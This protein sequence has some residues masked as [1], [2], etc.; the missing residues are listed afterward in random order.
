M[1]GVGRLEEVLGEV[2]YRFCFTFRHTVIISGQAARVKDGK[3]RRREWPVFA[4]FRGK[5]GT[6]R[7][8]E[9]KLWLSGHLFYVKSVANVA[10]T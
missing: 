5:I 3:V 10:A 4:Y 2:R 1:D 6:A 7:M 9:K 8:G